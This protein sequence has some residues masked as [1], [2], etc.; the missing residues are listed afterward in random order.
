MAGAWSGIAGQ[1]LADHEIHLFYEFDLP[2]P[3]P[4]PQGWWARFW[5]P[6]TEPPTI[7]P[8]TPL[9]ALADVALSG[10]PPDQSAALSRRYANEC[11]WKK[12]PGD[13]GSDFYPHVR[14]LA[15]GG[16]AVP[17]RAT[18]CKLS[19]HAQR[20][21]DSADLYE[22]SVP[23]EQRL[24]KRIALTWRGRELARLEAHGVAARPLTL[25]LD[26]VNL[27]VFPSTLKQLMSVRVVA[28]PLGGGALTPLEL[29]EVLVAL[30]HA[31]KLRWV[32]RQGTPLDAPAFSLDQLVRSLIG[33]GKPADTRRLR[34]YT[35]ARFATPMT[36]ADADHFGLYL[37]RHYTTDYVVDAQLAGIER[38]RTFETVGHT[39]SLEGSATIV[40]PAPGAGELPSFLLDYKSNT[41][42][43]HY[44]PIALLAT[45]ELGFLVDRTHRSVMPHHIDDI[46]SE[47]TIEKFAELRRDALLFRD[48][49]RFTQVSHIS[50]HNELNRAFRRA[51]GLDQMFREFTD[52]VNDIDAYLRTES[53]LRRAYSARKLT[54][55]GAGAFAGLTALT[56][57]RE[58]IKGF[59]QLLGHFTFEGKAD[60][61]GAVFGI[62]VFA[63][64]FWRT[65]RRVSS[66]HARSHGRDEATEQEKQEEQEEQE[67]RAKDALLD[68]MLQSS[69]ERA[70]A[71]S[72]ADLVR[73]P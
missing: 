9:A 30:T 4:P 48:W 53:E 19:V 60:L 10:L 3:P 44:V 43:Q 46:R 32:E 70:S 34:S 1:V 68:Q 15:C 7:C 52:D 69:E 12:A 73:R 26:A 8:S 66:H 42:R 29:L 6:D 47:E 16:E 33:A 65:Y 31:H 37:A 61:I 38:V 20:L 13:V 36:H 57:A 21:I 67:D 25:T 72:A 11:V 49:F 55:V 14:D 58:L 5:S 45:H 22:E 54:A 23:P 51:L 17:V 50:M 27:Y 39:V 59:A 40:A 24:R 35:Y 64:V 71:S 62:A 56:I 28:S 63:L 41:L 18:R 2:E